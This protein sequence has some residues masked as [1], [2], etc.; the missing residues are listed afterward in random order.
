M[1]ELADMDTALRTFSFKP[2]YNLD[3]MESSVARDE[4]LERRIPRLRSVK[5]R[6]LFDGCMQFRPLAHDRRVEISTS[7]VMPDASTVRRG[8]GFLR[9]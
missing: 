2:K 3:L 5:E 4:L 1:I 9:V 6:I 7:R 8:P